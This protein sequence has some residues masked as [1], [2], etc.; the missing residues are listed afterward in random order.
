M[1]T[2]PTYYPARTGLLLVDPCN[3]F[4]SGCGK[5][6]PRGKEIAEQVGLIGSLKAVVKAA[7]EKGI[8]VLIVPHHRWEPG[9]YERWRHAN[10]SRLASAKHQ[11]I[12]KGTWGGPAAGVGQGGARK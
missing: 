4:L 7:R 10:H 3:D 12:A 5:P 11:F 8:Q 2:K 1:A 9:R 6:W